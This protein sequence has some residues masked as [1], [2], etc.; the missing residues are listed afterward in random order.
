MIIITIKGRFRD[1]LN[2][3]DQM[4]YNK[5]KNATVRIELAS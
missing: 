1:I 5:N 4:D 3:L 2:E